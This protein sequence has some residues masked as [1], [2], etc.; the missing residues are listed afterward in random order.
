MSCHVFVISDLHLGGGPG[1]EMITAE[2]RGRLARFVRSITAQHQ[3]G[4]S[5]HLVL[6]GDIV[7]F[8]A[9]EPFAAFTADD[10]AAKKK[11]EHVLA[12]TAEVWEALADYARSGAALTLLTGNHDIELSLPA[13]RRLLLERL[14]PGRIDFLYDNQ[15]LPIGPLLIEHG[16]RY[17]GWNLVNHDQLRQVRSALSR[18]QPPPPFRTLPGSEMV[19][20]LMNPLKAKYSFIDLLKPEDSTV[21]PFLAMLEPQA[22]GALRQLFELGRLG[23]ESRQKFEEEHL[24]GSEAE[25][26]KGRGVTAQVRSV[27]SYVARELR[28]HELAESLWGD[29]KDAKDNKE[30]KDF[31]DSKEAKDTSHNPP[32]NTPSGGTSLVAETEC[33][34]GQAADFA[35]LWRLARGGEAQRKLVLG[36]LRK[37]LL[38]R[39]GEDAQAFRV[40]YESPA[41]LDPARESARRG[42]LVV[43]YG[44]THL[45]RRV[46]LENGARY[47]NTGTW[48]D[49][50][51]VP[52]AI[53]RPDTPEEQAMEQLSVFADDLVH[54]RL[55]SWRRQRPTFARIDLG[56]DLR[57]HSADVLLYQEPDGPQSLPDGVLQM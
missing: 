13:P 47:L 28:M 1:F 51:R 6:A 30:A 17:D 22:M 48:A 33:G 53:L 25:E 27:F 7:D 3:P 16:N 56:D 18:R 4:H 26:E 21:P 2:G 10:D 57:L 35:A 40:D 44:H 32:H 42:F 38:A 36:R 24:Y 23:A 41:Y 12:S 29:G 5:V 49:L 31:K 46:S 19:V 55:E 39:A 11:L 37:A 9:E 20:R 45:A 54:N 34:L 15:A 50:M 52:D 8:L 43:V 14:G